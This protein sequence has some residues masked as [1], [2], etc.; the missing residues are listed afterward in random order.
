MKA[1]LLAL[2]LALATSQYCP[3]NHYP[4]VK[5]SC[6]ACPSGA[7]LDTETGACTCPGERDFFQVST[8]SCKQCPDNSDS[9]GFSCDCPS[10]YKFRQDNL[11]CVPDPIYH[12]QEDEGINEMTGDSCV[13]CPAGATSVSGGSYR[14]C[15]CPSGTILNQYRNECTS[16][17][18][19]AHANP[20]TCECEDGYVGAIDNNL[21]LVCKQCPGTVEFGQCHCS[22]GKFFND[23]S[24]Q[25]E[26]P[27]AHGK[28]SPSGYL[29]C[30]ESYIEDD[31]KCITCAEDDPNSEFKNGN[32]QCK[33][34]YQKLPP[35]SEEI[36]NKIK[37]LIINQKKKKKVI[38]L[39]K[40]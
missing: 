13:K 22:N 39:K 20:N 15:E 17:G 14:Y 12:C 31:N 8:W 36:K 7:P 29:Q 16:C 18:S 30:D 9:L 4:D 26:D 5:L 33:A 28:V 38:I 40:E 19:I 25:C 6:K 21:N 11:T 3:D 32:C 35:F 24:Y 23:D 27:P 2:L 37:P 34:N 1:I 10:G